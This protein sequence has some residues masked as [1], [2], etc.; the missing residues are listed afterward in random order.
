D[1]AKIQDELVLLVKYRESVGEIKARTMAETDANAN[2]RI[3]ISLAIAWASPPLWVRKATN[4]V[5]AVCKPKE[6]MDVPMVVTSTKAEYN[7]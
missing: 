4:L 1:K 2:E 5:A 3:K 6:A 7:P